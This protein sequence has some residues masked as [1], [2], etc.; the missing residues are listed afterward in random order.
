MQLSTRTAES[1]PASASLFS[2]A[3]ESRRETV[4]MLYSGE[5]RQQWT[6]SPGNVD[7]RTSTGLEPRRS[8]MDMMLYSGTDMYQKMVAPNFNRGAGL[9]SRRATVDMLF[10]V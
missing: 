8:T 5:P 3:S 2:H 6:S 4:D 1:V 9:G 10:N 7:M